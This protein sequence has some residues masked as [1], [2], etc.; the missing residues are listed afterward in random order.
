MTRNAPLPPVTVQMRR[1]ADLQAWPWRI[2]TKSERVE[3]ERYEIVA[4]ARHRQR[5]RRSSTEG[6]TA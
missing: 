4:S 5:L 1:L 6:K 2:L 3:R